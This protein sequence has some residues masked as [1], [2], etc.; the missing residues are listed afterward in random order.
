MNRQIQVLSNLHIYKTA[1]SQEFIA[2]FLE[3]ECVE[4]I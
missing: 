4:C 3:I 1:D 2:A